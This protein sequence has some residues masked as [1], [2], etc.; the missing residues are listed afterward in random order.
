MA[1]I[2]QHKPIRLFA[3][4]SYDVVAHILPSID[5]LR[6]L[7]Y[8]NNKATMAPFNKFTKFEQVFIVAH[9]LRLSDQNSTL[10]KM[11]AAWQEDECTA[12]KLINLATDFENELKQSVGEL[13]FDKRKIFF[14]SLNE[15]GLSYSIDNIRVFCDRPSIELDEAIIKRIK[16]AIGILEIIAL[17][18]EEQIDELSAAEQASEN[19]AVQ[20]FIDM[21]YVTSEIIKDD[22]Q[23]YSSLETCVELTPEMI[24]TIETTDLCTQRNKIW[25]RKIWQGL[26]G[27]ESMVICVGDYHTIGEH[28]LLAAF[29]QNGWEIERYDEFG[30]PHQFDPLTA[31]SFTI[32]TRALVDF[33]QNSIT[34]CELRSAEE[35]ELD[36]LAELPRNDIDDF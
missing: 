21:E 18:T 35:A 8:L 9:S 29:F 34:N 22:S 13:V 11:A 10:K 31:T 3:E 16:Q 23:K 27:P 7:G 2:T 32:N 15:A 33:L 14:E 30:N 5:R 20:P 36:L 1:I 17:E 28:G 6:E 26:R 4:K 25:L 19:R 12:S 24:Q